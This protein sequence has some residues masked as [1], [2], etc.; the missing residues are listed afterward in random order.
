MVTIGGSGLGSS[1]PSDDAVSIGGKTTKI[2]SWSANS[3]QVELPSLAPG[4]YPLTF[5]FDEGLG[6]TS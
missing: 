5:Q 1:A 2:L 6:D 3:I 4:D